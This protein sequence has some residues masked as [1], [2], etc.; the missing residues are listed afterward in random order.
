MKEKT[1]LLGRSQ[2]LIGILTNPGP[3]FDERE[4][5][6]IVL[7]NSGLLHRVGPNRLYVKIA[8]RL[9]ADGFLVL[10]FDLSG[11]GDSRIPNE[12]QAYDEG[13][14]AITDTQEVMDYLSETRGIRQFILMGLCSGGS[15]AFKVARHDERVV[16]VNLI[17]GFAFPS[18]TYFA[19]AYSKS[20][21]SFR[22]WLRLLTGKSEIWGLIRGLI[23]FHTSKQ[24]RELTENLQVP[25]KEELL[26][27]LQTLIEREVDLCFIYSAD[28]AASYNY[29]K[30]FEEKIQSLPQS[31]RPRVDVLNGTDH[32][33]TLLCHQEMLIDLI[34]DWLYN[35]TQP[36]E[37]K[38]VTEVT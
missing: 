31:Q 11:I 26:S 4:R 24:T 27:D 14:V 30:I 7:L 23:R 33:F 13:A 28:G 5:P 10:R 38:E 22:S 6:A 9:V 36:K 25:G 8:R 2:S 17:E 15:N 16:G 3:E 35:F 32:L 37:V 12:T 1:V 18:S 34:K 29:R 19:R 20:L 21:L